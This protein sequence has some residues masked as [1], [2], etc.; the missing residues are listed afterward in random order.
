MHEQQTDRPRPCTQEYLILP[1]YMLV[2]MHAIL[3]THWSNFVFRSK[4]FG[5]RATTS[6]NI[7]KLKLSSACCRLLCAKIALSC[8]FVKGAEQQNHPV[9]DFIYFFSLI[10]VQVSAKSQQN[11]E[12]WHW[13]L[14]MIETEPHRTPR[15]QPYSTVWAPFV[16]S[17]ISFVQCSKHFQTMVVAIVASAWHFVLRGIMGLSLSYIMFG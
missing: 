5:S 11:I 1:L 6:I 14:C 13:Q 17:N 7:Y 8:H 16:A 10:F 15:Y 4:I 3:C 9:H 2:A 12:N